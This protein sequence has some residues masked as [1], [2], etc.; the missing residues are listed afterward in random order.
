[1]SAYDF[2][3]GINIGDL[4]ELKDRKVVIIGA[5]NVG[6]DVASQAYNCGAA[7]VIA[8]DIQKPAASGKEMENA[9][10]KARRL[11]GR[12]LPTATTSRKRSSIS[13]TAHPSTRPCHYVGGDVPI[14]DFLPPESNEGMDSG[15]RYRTDIRR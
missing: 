15:K 9:V 3:R 11:Y 8:V 2:L 13:K 10:A 7:S 4:P 5:G 12:N 14:L 6:M 1:V